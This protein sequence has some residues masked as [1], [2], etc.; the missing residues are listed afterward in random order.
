MKSLHRCIWLNAFLLLALAGFMPGGS[1]VLFAAPRDPGPISN[2]GGEL[3]FVAEGGR[4]RQFP[5]KRTD[6]H[7]EITGNI[8]RVELSQVFRNPYD[9]TIEA[10][11]VFPLPNKAAV[12]DMEIL[13]GDRTIKGVI[14]K[15]DEARRIYEAARLAGHVA[16][17]LDQDRP[18]IF[19]QSV[20]N[21][22]PGTEVVVRL[23]YFESLA[24][25]LGT[26][27]FS[28]PMVVGP[29]Y[30]PGTPVG[31]TGGGWSPDTADVPDASRIT[32]PVLEPEWRSG[33]DITVQV[34]L[35]AGTPLQELVSPSHSVTVDRRGAGQASVRLD[36]EDSI[37]N[38]DFVLR[39]RIDGEAPNLVVVPHRTT[40]DGYFLMLL[41]PEARPAPHVITPK[42]MIFVV[43]CSGS[44]SGSPIAKA[45]EAIAYALEH[46]NPLDNFQIIRF[47]NESE[48]FAPEPV[49]ATPAHIAR[50]L[51]YVSGLSGQGGTIMLEGVK[52]ALGYRD[53]PQRL[54]IISF[55]TDGYIGNEDQILSYLHEHL[56]GAR[57]FSFGVGSSVNRHLLDK[58]AE[59]GRGGVEYVLLN[60]DFKAAVERFYE[61]I[62]NPYLTDIRLDWGHLRVSET[63][64]AEVPDLYLGQPVVLHGRYMEPG[65]GSVLLRGR[66]AGKPY[67]QRFTVLLPDEHQAGEAIGAL[68]ARSR[69]ED[70]SRRQIVDPQPERIEEITDLA[71]AHRLMSAYTSFVAVEERTLTGSEGPLRVDVPVCL[72]EGLSFEGIFGRPSGGE[73]AGRLLIDS[74]PIVG[75][76]YQDVLTLSP[77]V[78][79]TDGDGRANIH[80]SRSTHVVTL[81]DGASAEFGRGHRGVVGSPKA[82]VSAEGAERSREVLTRIE[83]AKQTVRP[84]EP[85]EI[86]V[87][88]ENR[89]R[90]PV[91]VPAEMSVAKGTARFLILDARLQA[92]QHPVAR[93]RPPRLRLRPGVRV[94]FTVTLNGSGGYRLDRPGIYH[95]V[96]MGSDFGLADSN[97]LIVTITP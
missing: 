36:E 16:A 17:L 54:R 87:T 82:T 68:W 70:L 46:L 38:R 97:R 32:P 7:A 52:A 11:Y 19:T 73:L 50:A 13:V 18:N 84:G 44:M 15:R 51:E 91:Q 28:F 4:V 2:A 79:G 74:L 20:T 42:E 37:P 88:I 9:M 89:H 23:R 31:K 61:R 33:H 66:L 92:L 78:A 14:K 71:L 60:G 24:Y 8:A 40:G 85:I 72:P 35:D 41:Q 59:F 64:P 10:V 53:D 77:G 1:T 93:S 57:L 29:R 21:I 5:L 22:L 63:Y 80:G 49:P 58:M 95:I 75:R 48:S 67:E 86:S 3:R 56:G 45:K 81:V 30:I 90:R 96:F 6:V 94:T 43:D 55:M 34:Q 39:Y 27:E 65:T 25:S 76:N 62:R 83:A 69:I 47:S 26:Y 12:D